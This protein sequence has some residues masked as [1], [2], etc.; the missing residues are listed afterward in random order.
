MDFQE[1]IG[2][3]LALHVVPYVLSKLR[4]LRITII[5]QTIG[6]RCHVHALTPFLRAIGTS[7]SS[8][9]A[10]KFEVFPQPANS[11]SVSE[12]T[13]G[14]NSWQRLCW[15]NA[16]TACEI[17]TY[18]KYLVIYFLIFLILLVSLRIRFVTFFFI[19]PWLLP[20][21]DFFPFTFFFHTH[22]LYLVI[23]SLICYKNMFSSGCA[24][25]LLEWY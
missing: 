8:C 4:K 9:W 21:R 12:F 2:S 20:L 6:N 5:R 19:N 1:H 22:I 25:L 16:Y 15:V 14:L 13:Y 17:S 18:C 24:F 11:I 10:S 23:F 3:S 7:K